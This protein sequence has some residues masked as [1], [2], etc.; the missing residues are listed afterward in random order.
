MDA[1]SELCLCVRYEGETNEGHFH[2]DGVAFF[3]G[4]HHYKGTFSKGL[5]EGFGVFTMANGLKYEVRGDMTKKKA[6]PHNDQCPER[7]TCPHMVESECLLV[8]NGSN[9]QGE[10]VGNTSMGRGTYTW[11]HG[12]TYVGEVHN[13]IRHGMGTYK[14][15]KTSLSYT[16][17]WHRGRWH[18]Q[19]NA[20]YNM[21]GTSWYKGDWVMSSREGR[22]VR[23]YPSGNIYSGE[24]KNNVRHGEGTMRWLKMRQQYVGGWQDGV[25]HG[26]GTLVWMLLRADGSQYSQSNRYEGDFFHGQ[27]HGKGTFFYAGGAIYKG[28]WRNNKKHGQG[29]FTFKDGRVFEGEFVEDQMMDGSRAPSPLGGF[30]LSGSD[31]TILGPDMALS[32]GC[33]LERIPENRR[34]VERKQVSS[35]PSKVEKMS[36]AGPNALALANGSQVESVVLQ[37]HTELRSIYSFYSRLGRPHSPDNTFRLARLSFWR[38]LKDCN[39]H[40]LGLTLT[41]MDRFIGE[42]ADAAEVCSPFTPLLLRQLLSSLVIVA[43]H[44][45]SK[46]MAFENNLLAA[47]LSKLITDSILPNAKT[48]K[49]FLFKH[50][51]FSVEA[52]KYTTRCWEVYETFCKASAACRDKTMTCRHLLWMFKDLHLLDHM[53]TTARLLEIITAESGDHSNLS[54]HLEL[55]LTFLEFFEVLVGCSEVKHQQVSDVT[56]QDRPLLDIPA[57]KDLSEVEVNDKMALCTKYVL[58]TNANQLLQLENLSNKMHF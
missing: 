41:Q 45:Y 53:L 23:R 40:R 3:E 42:E 26:R 54:S 14:C 43:Y 30:P 48:V 10:F 13:G 12:S 9:R 25:Q 28:E 51:D 56:E 29:K 11:P 50:P 18:G 46:D 39:V 5:M 4:G 55:E 35:L 1:C 19:G 8:I 37:N 2:G 47:C 33:L 24:W 15:A 22:G 44:I 58:Y 31:S 52:M 21:D 36:A 7:E 27:R 38:L 6:L 57:K 49:D 32:I 34:N 17:Q 20:Y 16:G